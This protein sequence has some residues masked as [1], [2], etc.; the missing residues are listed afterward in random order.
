LQAMPPAN[1]LNS[2]RT[3]TMPM[4]G[5]ACASMHAAAKQQ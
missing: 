5:S 1:C 3:N 2:P 4:R